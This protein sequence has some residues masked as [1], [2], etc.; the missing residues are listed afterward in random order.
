[1]WHGGLRRDSRWGPPS[2]SKSQPQFRAWTKHE[3]PRA[4][5]VARIG[6]SPHDPKNFC[7]LES[8]DDSS[9][10]RKL[11][12]RRP[13]TLQYDHSLSWTVLSGLF[14]LARIH[15][16]VSYPPP[17]FVGQVLWQPALVGVTQPVQ[18]YRGLSGNS[19]RRTTRQAQGR[20]GYAGFFR[21]FQY[22]LRGDGLN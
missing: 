8:C 10:N 20:R 19:Q 16:H 11:A 13:D 2:H 9:W 14:R 1:M 7:R 3:L 6:A 22:Q 21:L 17:L 18:G 5:N 15:R 12:T 4:L